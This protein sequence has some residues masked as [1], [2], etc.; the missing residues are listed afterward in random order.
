MSFAGAAQVATTRFSAADCRRSGLS[1]TVRFGKRSR[2]SR[3]RA[4]V[5]SVLP[6][7]ATTMRTRAISASGA[8]SEAMQA[9]MC[10]A[11]FSAGTATRM[12]AGSAGVIGRPSFQGFAREAAAPRCLGGQLLRTIVKMGLTAPTGQRRRHDRGAGAS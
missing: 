1:I 2:R 4:F 7:S 9:S 6:P 12:R 11:S 5:P 3:S 8:I 10:A